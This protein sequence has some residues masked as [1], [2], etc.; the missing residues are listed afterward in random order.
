MTL[1][2]QSEHGSTG[3]RQ[4]ES[5][6]EWQLGQRYVGSEWHVDRFAFSWNGTNKIFNTKYMHCSTRFNQ[7][8]N[9]RSYREQGMET[10]SWY[11]WGTAKKWQKVSIISLKLRL[12]LRAG[13]V[14]MSVKGPHMTS[15]CMR[16]YDRRSLL[17]LGVEILCSYNRLQQR[18][19]PAPLL[20]MY[21]CV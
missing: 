16:S 19:D 6:R 1:S 11:R 12:H 15:V 7:Q 8:V 5:E 18:R 2:L 17:T 3:Q 21:E 4:G 9:M 20:C 10:F 14:V 13:I